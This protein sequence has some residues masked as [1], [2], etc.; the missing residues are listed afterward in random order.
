MNR[1]EYERRLDKSIY[2]KSRQAWI[3]FI[4]RNSMFVKSSTYNSCYGLK[5]PLTRYTEKYLYALDM[6]ELLRE[7]G[8]TVKL[9]S[10][11]YPMA[12]TRLSK[13]FLKRVINR[14]IIK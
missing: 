12:K 1:Q 14:E 3:E 8:F 7:L 6:M 2:L 13:K 4:K 10:D 5:Q 9:E 11:G